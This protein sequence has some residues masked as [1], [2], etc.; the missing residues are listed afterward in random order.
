MSRLIIKDAVLVEDP[1]L[2]IAAEEPIP[3]RGALIVSLERWLAERDSLA[4]RPEALG[5]RLRSDQPPDA[6]VT[7][8]PGF[9][10]I[11]LEFPKFRDGRAY[12]YAR[13]LRERFGFTGELR[14]V[15]D[16]LV[17]QLHLMVRA[18]FNAFEFDHAEPLQAYEAAVSR[19][20]VWY[21]PTGDGRPT[22][23]ELR[24]RL[25]ADRTG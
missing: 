2:T 23:L 3:E 12:T 7:D 25:R 20:S 1:Y 21:Q 9:T 17:D 4:A 16:V 5:V 18:G 22:A 6:I 19:M 13:L 11:A 15:G 14:A 10:V 24:R 8:L